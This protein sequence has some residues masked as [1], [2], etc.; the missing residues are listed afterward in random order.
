MV[1]WIIDRVRALAIHIEL[2]TFSKRPHLTFIIET[3]YLGDVE[4]HDLLPHAHAWRSLNRDELSIRLVGHRG[5]EK[6][7]LLHL[8][9]VVHISLI[10]LLNLLVG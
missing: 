7:L 9:W 6:L 10:T 4:V 2:S 5:C 1:C 8:Y 3:A